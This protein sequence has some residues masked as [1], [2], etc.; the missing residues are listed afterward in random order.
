MVLEWETYSLKAIP[1]AAQHGLLCGLN[2]ASLKRSCLLQH[3]NVYL[4]FSKTERTISMNKKCK[5]DPCLNVRNML[6]HEDYHFFA[7]T[8]NSAGKTKIRQQL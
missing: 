8:E 1:K 7:G 2:C 5:G 6:K 4:V 3:R